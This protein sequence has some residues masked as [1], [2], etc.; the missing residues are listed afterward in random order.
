ME[1]KS[2]IGNGVLWASAFII[3]T[4]ILFSASRHTQTAIADNVNTNYGFTMLTTSNG[5]GTDYL[6]VIDDKTAMLLVYV[7][8]DPQNKR[9]ID[10]V[11]TWYLPSMFASTRQ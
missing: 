6:W 1:Q 3:A 11:A 4:A 7:V 8:Q 2:Y 5:H 9:S 10:R